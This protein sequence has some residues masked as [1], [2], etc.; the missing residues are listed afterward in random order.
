[1]DLH[2]TRHVKFRKQ[3]TELTTEL[4]LAVVK[5][6]AEVKPVAGAVEPVA[7]GGDILLPPSTKEKN[8]AGSIEFKKTEQRRSLYKF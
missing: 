6:N 5:A 1:M 3:E 8:P 4:A 2:S 7:R